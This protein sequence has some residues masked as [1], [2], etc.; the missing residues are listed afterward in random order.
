MNKTILIILS[1]FLLLNS[2]AYN[3]YEEDAVDTYLDWS[4]YW[5]YQGEESYDSYHRARMLAERAMREDPDNLMAKLIYGYSLLKLRIWDDD[6]PRKKTAKKVFTDIIAE[7]KDNYRAHLGLGITN[8][9]LCKKNT[10]RLRDFQRLLTE[11]EKLM[12]MKSDIDKLRKNKD[13]K[14]LEDNEIEKKEIQ[15]VKD[16]NGFITMINLVL[17]GEIFPYMEYKSLLRRHKN[18]SLSDIQEAL[19]KRV[20]D[21]VDSIDAAMIGYPFNY[22]VFGEDMNKLKLLIEIAEKYY[23][24]EYT[25]LLDNAETE[26]KYCLKLHDKYESTFF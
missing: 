2:C 18:P 7:E 14:D 22:A 1:A 26:F 24:I 16:T 10:G 4:G 20:G 21:L 8:I 3:K 6:N 5:Y 13:V 19:E 23:N 17:N 15:L 9:M 25:K 12:K 11:I